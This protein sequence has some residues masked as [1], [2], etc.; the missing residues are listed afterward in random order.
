[1][2]TLINDC[3]LLSF[4]LFLLFDNVVFAFRLK[5][6]SIT[7]DNI[8][9]LLAKDEALA[10]KVLIANQSSKTVNKSHLDGLMDCLKGY[11]VA[12]LAYLE[13]LVLDKDIQVFRIAVVAHFHCGYLPFCRMKDSTRT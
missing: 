2:N 13:F 6:D 4:F 11:P 3:T 10:V 8:D 12:T 1:M 5:S 7:W 9:W